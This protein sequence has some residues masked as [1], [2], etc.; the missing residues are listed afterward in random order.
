MIGT[1]GAFIGDEKTETQNTTP[2]SFEL[3]SLFRKMLDAGC[4]H[5]VMEA[6]S[7]GFKL[8]R[9]D[10]IRFAYG[11][12]LNLS[13]DHISPAEHKDFDEYKDCHINFIY[14]DKNTIQYCKQ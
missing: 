10:G 7:Q 13:T 2:E 14:T 9:T 12:F 8:K 5:V 1:M 6:S 11:A 3:H 4:T